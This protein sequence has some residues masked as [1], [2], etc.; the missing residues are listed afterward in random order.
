MYTIEVFWPD[1]GARGVSLQP[2]Y[3]LL[4]YHNHVTAGRIAAIYPNQGSSSGGYEIQINGTWLTMGHDVI[5]VEIGTTVATIVRQN[6]THIICITGHIKMDDKIQTYDVI[7]TSE[8]TGKSICEGCFTYVRD[9]DPKPWL[10]DH[11]LVV[12]GV[13]SVMLL[14]FILCGMIGN[15]RKLRRPVTYRPIYGTSKLPGIDPN[16]NDD[17]VPRGGNMRYSTFEMPE[18]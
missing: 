2:W 13:V 10:E 12:L 8:S 9:D 16:D 3:V 15:Y 7:V 1:D 11:K 14:S 6:R 18:D 17:M 4:S 5:N